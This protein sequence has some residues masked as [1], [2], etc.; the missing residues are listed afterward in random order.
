MF[1][2]TVMVQMADVRWTTTAVEIAAKRAQ[3]IGAELALVEMIASEC[4]NW[5]GIEP[6]E[7]QFSPTERED[8]K[9]Y[10]GI[11]RKYGVPVSVHVYKY[12]SLS[13]CIAQAADE[14]DAESVF[15]TLPH[16]LIPFLHERQV[17]HL[18][19]L[20]E[21]HYHH[22]FTLDVPPTEPAWN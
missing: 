8:I 5:Q 18:S 21:D 2:P 17:L 3:E 13:E 4:L 22:L 16:T 20:L 14:L 1:K 7:Y 15:V 9:H 10:R 11:A 6:D 12:D 19:H